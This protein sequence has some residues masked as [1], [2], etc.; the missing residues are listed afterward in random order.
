VRTLLGYLKSFRGDGVEDRERPNPNV[1]VAFLV[2]AVV[3]AFFGFRWM[4]T[5]GGRAPGDAGWTLGGS[6]AGGGPTTIPASPAAVAVRFGAEDVGVA[7]ADGGRTSSSTLPDGTP[8][9]LPGTTGSTGSTGSTGTTGPGDTTTTV[10]TTV[11]STEPPTTTTSTTEPTTSTSDPTTSTSDP[12]TTT[13]N[14]EP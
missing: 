8:I 4:G 13:T 11:I 7:D 12:T 2:I 1:G 3:V 10:V 9:D 5:E 14:V 6:P